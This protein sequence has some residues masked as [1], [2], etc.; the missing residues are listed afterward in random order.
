M[1]TPQS[2]LAPNFICQ[3]FA[4]AHLIPVGRLPA[5]LEA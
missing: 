1:S 4:L 3:K 2:H 5:F